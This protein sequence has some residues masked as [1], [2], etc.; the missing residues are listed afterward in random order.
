MLDPELELLLEVIKLVILE[1]SSDV[2]LLTLAI[3]L[4]LEEVGM[5]DEE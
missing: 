3:E 4:S 1:P 2:L 5:P